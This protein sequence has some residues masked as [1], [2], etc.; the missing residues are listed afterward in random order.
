MLCFKLQVA[1][2]LCWT[3]KKIQ[4]LIVVFKNECLSSL[5]LQET[6]LNVLF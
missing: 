6:K 1:V 3:C 2:F 4:T 5:D